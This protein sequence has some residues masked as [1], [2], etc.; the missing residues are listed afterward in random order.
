[1]IQ[2]QA[3]MMLMMHN[4][5]MKLSNR[6]NKSE[7]S[8]YENGSQTARTCSITLMNIKSITNQQTI[9]TKC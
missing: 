1:M 9:I 3:S 4:I 6:V 2:Q 5:F 7:V 8:I